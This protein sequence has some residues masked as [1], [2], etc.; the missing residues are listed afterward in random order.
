MKT[1]ISL[2]TN[3]AK[4]FNRLKSEDKFP[5]V[6]FMVL[7]TLTLT[8]LILNVPVN[9]KIGLMT[10]SSMDMGLP[11]AQVDAAMQAVYSMRFIS[12]AG[13][14]IWELIVLFLHASVLF[15]AARIA[16]MKI[17]FGKVAHL[18]IICCIVQ[19]IGGLVNTSLLYMRGIEHIS[20]PSDL[21]M[22]GMNMLIPACRTDITLYTFLSY[23]NPFQ[24]WY[25]I[26]VILGM[27]VVTGGSYAKPVAA[28]ILYWLITVAVPVAS[29][30]LSQSM[31][32]EI[33][34]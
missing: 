4:S 19:A 17:S 8:N 18:I 26:L 30:W 33:S 27:K 3:P 11:E 9:T 25:A 1:L 7:L 31:I 29:T 23:F 34:F 20:A 21:Q 28:G 6:A 14:F 10:L 16:G 15:A 32:Q 12:M 13:L 22:T 2:I 5:A 24:L